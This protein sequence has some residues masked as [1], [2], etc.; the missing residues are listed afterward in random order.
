VHQAM[1]FVEDGHGV[2]F[3]TGHSGK[4]HWFGKRVGTILCYVH[5][6]TATYTCVRV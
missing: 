2:D 5:E 6:T 3:F 1:E 4:V